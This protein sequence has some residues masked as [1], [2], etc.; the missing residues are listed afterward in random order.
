MNIALTPIVLDILTAVIVVICFIVSWKR[1]LVSTV[2]RLVGCAASILFGW[3]ASGKLATI[4]YDRFLKDK[5]VDIVSQRVANQAVSSGTWGVLGRFVDRILSAATGTDTSAASETI[6]DNMLSQPAT[7]VVRA[8]L[9]I[10]LFFLLMLVVK[11]LNRAFRGINKVPVLGGA[12]KLL[13]G[14][15]GIAEGLLV[16][17]IAVAAVSLIVTLTN[18]SLTW[19]NTDLIDVSKLFSLLYHFNPIKAVTESGLLTQ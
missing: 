18:N 3:W 19:L 9:F 1:G 7:A 2:I 17:Y 16:C 4:V 12:N 14:V 10:L 5:L 13:G 8:I 15:I 11:G 6:V